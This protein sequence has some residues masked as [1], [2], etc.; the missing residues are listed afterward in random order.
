MLG[1]SIFNDMKKEPD[2][3]TLTCVVSAWGPE[4]DLQML[5]EEFDILVNRLICMISKSDTEDWCHC[6]AR[7]FPLFQVFMLS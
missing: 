7:W 4:T 2:G 3:S 6:N 5:I 1:K